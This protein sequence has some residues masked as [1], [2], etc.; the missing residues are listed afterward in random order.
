MLART[1]DWIGHVDDVE[2]LGSAEAGDLDS[3]HDELDGVST[4]GVNF[5]D[6]HHRRS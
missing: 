6:T 1:R 3:A 2:D 5:A 4:A